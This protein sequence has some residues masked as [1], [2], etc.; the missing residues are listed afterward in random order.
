MDG[1]PDGENEWKK[2]HKYQR[3]HG[4]ICWAIPRFTAW[5]IRNTIIA[6]KELYGAW[7][8]TCYINSCIARIINE[9]TTQT[10]V[11]VLPCPFDL[12]HYRKW[13]SGQ[14]IPF[15]WYNLWDKNVPF[16]SRESNIFR[17]I[18]LKTGF[19]LSLH[20]SKDVNW[21]NTSFHEDA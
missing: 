20:F 16:F 8:D 17:T 4:T 6:L 11:C 5:L 7:G 18:K 15:G 3:T 2:K 12:S 14:K 21:I 13:C 9:W 1:K 19:S 10:L